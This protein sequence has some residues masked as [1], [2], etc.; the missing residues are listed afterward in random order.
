MV[1]IR[2]FVAM[3]VTVIALA[4]LAA[5]VW[6]RI[7]LADGAGPASTA[8]TAGP[9][10]LAGA[11]T[12]LRARGG[13]IGDLFAGPVGPATVLLAECP[14]LPCLLEM[15]IGGQPGYLIVDYP[16]PRG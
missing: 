14:A 7:G 4:F 13:G 10:G 1:N 9:A 11:I 3:V 15:D 8:G 5:I 2:L 12:G 6:P 16:N